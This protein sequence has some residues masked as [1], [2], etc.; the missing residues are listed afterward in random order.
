MPILY[1]MRTVGDKTYSI[2]KFDDDLNVEATYTLRAISKTEF[3]CDCPA[4]PRPSCRH[5]KMIPFFAV[6]GAIDSNRFYC[7][8]TQM[9]HTPLYDPLPEGVTMISMADPAAVHDAIAEAVGE[10][11]L[12]KPAPRPST[13]L[14]RPK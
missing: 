2:T 4:G 12:S 7:Y 6:H 5:R 14:R 10:P 1:N 8:D 3:S 13:P 11:P 9:W